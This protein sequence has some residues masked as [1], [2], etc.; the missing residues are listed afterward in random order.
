MA[1][2]PG[3]AL[4]LAGA[5][6]SHANVDALEQLKRAFGCKLVFLVCDLLPID[7]PSIVTTRQ[8]AVFKD[9]LIKI[10]DVADAIVTPNKVTAKRLEGFLAEGGRRSRCQIAPMRQEGPRLPRRLANLPRAEARPGDRRAVSCCVSPRYESA[11]MCFG[12]S[13]YARSFS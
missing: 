2:G 11:N 8:R 5:S 12:S 1:L 10:G 6:W 9:F 4:V 7:Y 13:L 3:D